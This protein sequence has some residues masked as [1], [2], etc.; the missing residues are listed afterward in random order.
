MIQIDV[1]CGLRP[2]D[3]SWRTFPG[4][5]LANGRGLETGIGVVQA[6]SSATEALH[7]ECHGVVLR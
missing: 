7:I 3:D 6:P 1:V 5:R 2:L 4:A